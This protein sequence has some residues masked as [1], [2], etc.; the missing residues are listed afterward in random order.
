[1]YITTC[2]AAPLAALCLCLSFSVSVSVSLSNSVCL[3]LSLSLS[4]SLYLSVC[5]SVCLSLS[6]SLYFPLSKALLHGKQPDQIRGSS[7]I[8]GQCYYGG[9]ATTDTVLYWRR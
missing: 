8:Y 7:E 2:Y 9:I 3:S 4:L 1:M 5:L 6:L